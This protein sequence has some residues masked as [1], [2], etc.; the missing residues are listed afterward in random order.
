MSIENVFL[1]LNEDVARADP[2]VG[3]YFINGVWRA[4]VCVHNLRAW[5]SRQDVTDAD[6]NITHTYW[7][8]WRICIGSEDVLPEFSEHPHL[9]LMSDCY[10]REVEKASQ[11]Q[12][13]LY[14]LPE[15]SASDVAYLRISP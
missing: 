12:W 9:V 5:D 13:L 11:D 4:D 8:G 6:G 10:A 1:F 7:P 3:A 14:L 15:V 2:V